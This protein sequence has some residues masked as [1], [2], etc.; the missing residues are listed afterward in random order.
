[1]LVFQQNSIHH[2]ALMKIN[3]QL[4]LNFTSKIEDVLLV[5]Y[6]DGGR[7]GTWAAHTTWV[8]VGVGTPAEGRVEITTWVSSS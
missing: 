1:M 4:Y 8:G 5:Q 7:A 2:C 6:S 3:V